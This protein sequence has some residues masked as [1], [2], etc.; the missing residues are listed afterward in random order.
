M[1]RR[2]LILAACVAVV[3]LGAAWWLYG[4]GL[5]AEERRLVGTWRNL[6][7]RT[8]E[9]VGTMTFLPD[10]THVY[11]PRS[12]QPRPGSRSHLWHIRDG[13]IVFDYE[14]SAIRRLLRP[15]APRLGLSVGPAIGAPL[16]M[17]NGGLTIDRRLFIRAP[18]D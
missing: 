15:L 12:G 16:T 13:A 5:T 17:E 18:A 9:W 1:T 10:H 11:V 14:P 4:D 8:G 3:A 2:R 7:S 6:D